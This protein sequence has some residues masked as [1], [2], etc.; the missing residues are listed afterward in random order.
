MEV[1]GD[2]LA[3]SALWVSEDLPFKASLERGHP[4]ILL[5]AGENC[6]GK[7]LFVETLRVWARRMGASSP[8][9]QPLEVA[10]VSVSIRERTGAGA[11]EGASFRRA[12]MFGNET[13]QSTGATSVNAVVTAFRTMGARAQD[14]KSALLVLDEPEL[15]LSEGYAK[16]MGALLADEACKLDER[17]IGVAVVTHSRGLAAAFTREV[18]RVTGQQ[19][20]FAKLGAPM[21]LSD[22]LE[23]PEEHSVADLLSLSESG[24]NGF[25]AVTRFLDDTARARK[26]EAAAQAAAAEAE[27]AKPR[28]SRARRPR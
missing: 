10:T 23:A 9:G 13:E 15:G 18:K 24:R 6:S 4:R 5:V 11:I 7:S 27:A 3:D 16:A 17:A 28:V 25:L 20:S 19:P 2:M 22:W 26:A 21:S 8:D 14:G 12:M 1:A